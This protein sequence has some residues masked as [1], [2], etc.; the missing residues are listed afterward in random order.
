W[1]TGEDR[2]VS[3]ELPTR[4]NDAGKLELDVD[5]RPVA[6]TNLDKLMYPA[7]GFTKAD[8]IAYYAR[9]AP[10]LLPYVRDR[11]LTLKRFPDGVGGAYFY[12]KRCPSHR[13]EWV[14][15]IPIWT[16]RAEEEFDYCTITEP[17]TL[18]WLANLADLEIHPFLGTRDHLDRPT[19]MVLDLDPGAPAGLLDA[20]Q[21]ALWLRGMFDQLE[22]EV[23]VKSSGGRGIH[24]LVPLNGARTYEEVQPFARGVAETL[25]RRFAERVVSTQSRT[26]RPGK[27][28]IDWSQNARH[29][30]TAAVYSLRA[31]DRPTVSMPLEWDE[32]ERAVQDD[33]PA[34]L[35]F[36]AGETIAR[37]EE[38][39]DLFEPLLSLTQELPDA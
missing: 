21:V 16:E 36:D 17:A 5:G 25:E 28:L 24:L 22:L 9:I 32:V 7:T 20:C 29:K 13:P 1:R 4:L 38:R 39:G 30:T 12:E 3:D 10:V 15:T 35:I 2:G 37:V 23:F 11:P 34:R 19:W 27:V 14:E 26:K 18:V 8:V 6:V 31:R 33:D